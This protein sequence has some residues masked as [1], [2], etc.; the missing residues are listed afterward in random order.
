MTHYKS[1]LLLLLIALS[2]CS[3][4]LMKPS[5]RPKA[6]GREQLDITYLSGVFSQVTREYNSRGE[7]SAYYK[8]LFISK[9]GKFKIEEEFE[10][11]KNTFS[12]YYL[13]VDDF[14]LLRNY[15]RDEYPELYLIKY[16]EEGFELQRV[17]GDIKKSQ[18][19]ED[20]VLLEGQWLENPRRY[21]IR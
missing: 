2:G 10:G 17:S 16:L 3:Y 20:T 19:I 8:R 11:Y 4:T 6:A 21:F 7:K 14:L 15:E 18:L 5:P 12:G 9:S 1:L 13:I